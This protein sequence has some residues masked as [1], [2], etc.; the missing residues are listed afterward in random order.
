MIIKNRDEL[1]SHG[2]IEGRKSILDILE[3][4]LEA[5]DSYKAVK[6]LVHIDDEKLIVDNLKFDL[7]KIENIYVLGAGKATMPIGMAL[8]DILGERIRDGLI[9][10]KKGQKRRL[11]RI[12][13]IE[14]S[15]PIPDEAGL[16][17]AKELVKIAKN[18]K[19][20]DLVFSA[21]TGGSSAL[22]PLPAKGISLE[23][24]I[25][26]TDLL[27]KSGAV[28]QEINAVRKHLSA[29]KGGRLAKLI[30]PAEIV[31]LTVSDVI[32]DPLDYITDLTVP[33]TSTFE[34]AV[35]ALKKYGLWEKV[36]N[37]VRTHL[38]KGLTDPS[39]ETPKDFTGM[40]VHTFIISNN[41][42]VCEAAKNRAEELGFNSI[43]LSTMIEGES[44]EAGI[45]L[46]GIAKEI[47]KNGRPFKPPCA[48]ISGGETTVTI[49]GEHGEG[50][51]NQEFVLGFSLKIDGNKNIT[52]SAIDTDGTDGPTDIAGGIADGYTLKRAREK[53]I[54]VYE[55]LMKH[56][57]S[58]VL[59]TLKDTIY[60]EP[61]GTNVM[62]LRVIIIT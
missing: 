6:K 23:D 49:E 43:I 46:A 24:K 11:K 33:D 16:E 44:R 31:N 29:I 42:A 17:G 1:C 34:D 52:V 60:T 15:H 56:N 4:A 50:G 10:V 30:H 3:H 28:I 37:S 27:L 22:A 53:D 18:A 62:N 2:N 41:E 26:V 39:L 57:T 7:S 47:E 54:D 25:E 5:V 59:R 61:T 21:I 51:R 19:K 35:F 45:V 20:G 36:S 8:E 55:N 32:G 9:I 40:K 14:A 58:H 38:E 13:V 12:K 48:L